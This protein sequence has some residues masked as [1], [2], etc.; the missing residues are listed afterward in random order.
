[1]PCWALFDRQDAAYRKSVLGGDAIK[2]A[3]EAASTFGW[4]RYV[5][6]EGAVIGLT[7][8]GVSAPAD[9]AYRHLGITVEAVVDAA[10]ARV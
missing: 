4:E 2:I 6:P 10:L 8:F 1:M 3:V 7:S 9:Q 5:G